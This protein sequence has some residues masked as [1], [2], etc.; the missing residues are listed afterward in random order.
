MR[1]GGKEREREEKAYLSQKNKVENKGATYSY[2]LSAHRLTCTNTHNKEY[3]D[4]QN[5]GL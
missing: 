4:K 2:G 1:E 5:G 3:G